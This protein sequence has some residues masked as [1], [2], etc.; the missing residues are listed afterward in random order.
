[1]EWIIDEFRW[2]QWNWA[3]SVF[4][5]LLFLS[6]AGLTVWDAIAPGSS[7]KRLLPIATTRGDRLFIG[8]MGSIG[9]ALLW[10]A[11][12]GNQAL[13]LA[14]LLVATYNVALALRG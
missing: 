1:M 9:L 5:I 3:G 10:L 14:L 2:M 4:F 13:W 7:K 8:I 6:I 11:L 12:I